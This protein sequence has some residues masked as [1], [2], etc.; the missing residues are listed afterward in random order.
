VSQTNS[1]IYVSSHFK[2]TRNLHVLVDIPNYNIRNLLYLTVQVANRKERI[3][4]YQSLR[5]F[6]QIIIQVSLKSVELLNFNNKST[7]RSALPQYTIRNVN[8]SH[9]CCNHTI[10]LWAYGAQEIFGHKKEEI[11]GVHTEEFHNLFHFVVF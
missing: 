7:S 5:C 6:T 11:T 9:T 10:L 1:N 8:S 3:V 2:R 4:L